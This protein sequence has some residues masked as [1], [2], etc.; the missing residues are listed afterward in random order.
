MIFENLKPL[1]NYTSIIVLLDESVQNDLDNPYMIIWRVVNN[2]DAN[3]DIYLD[4]IILIDASTKNELDNF[5]RE[6]PEDV[7]CNKNTIENLKQKG[8]IDL[9][10]E[11]M[12]KFQIFGI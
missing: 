10:E 5:K 7:V 1:K 9:S 3:T 12:R 8:L 4:D 2:I 6:W 11:E